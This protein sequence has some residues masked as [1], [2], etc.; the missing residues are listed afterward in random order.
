M[1]S[2]WWRPATALI[3]AML[4]II[5]STAPASATPSDDKRA[6]AAQ[7]AKRQERLVQRGEVLN[8]RSKA[9]KLKLDQLAADLATTKTAIASRTEEVTGIQK[10]VVAFAVN[11]YIYGQ[12]GAISEV[13]DGLTADGLATAAGREGYAALIIGSANDQVDQLRAVRQDTERLNRDLS[14]K[15]AQ[16][17]KL[18]AQIASEQADIVQIKD[19][20]AKLSTKVSGEL[21]Q[22]VERET[23]QREEAAAAKARADIERQR[24]DFAKAAERQ[25]LE[26]AK[27][28]AA[29]NAQLATKRAATDAAARDAAARVVQTTVPM[30]RPT[31][32]AAPVRRPATAQSPPAIDLP[33]APAPNRGA[34]TAIAEAMRQLGKPYVFGTNGPDT[35]DCSGLTQWAWAKAGVAMD[36]YTGSQANQFPR[37]SVDQL[38]PGD[39]VFFNVD[40]GHMGMYIGNDQIIQAPRTGDVVK[41]T[42]LNRGNVVVAVRPG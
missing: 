28:A 22:L 35:F 40:L 37:I 6:E 2:K 20:L 42:T 16:W 15:E 39:L 14:S 32:A 31:G 30:A 10:D 11:T 8:E 38:Q 17:T 18:D 9:S 23:R 7:I 21:V 27:A 24:Q 29:V 19:D 12:H 4:T 3:A 41:I 34:A 13:V 5:P 33:V 26:A 1:S 25:R 36:H